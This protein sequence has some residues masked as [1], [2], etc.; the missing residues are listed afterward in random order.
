M[1]KAAE[2]AGR[3]L[4]RDF[5]EVENL[6]VSKKG[7]GDFVSAADL[8]AE[9]TIRYE[10]EKA[11][12]TFGFLMEESGETKGKD[13][14]RRFIVDPLDGTTNFLHGI[15]HWSISIA[16]EEKG[17]ITAGL[18]LNPITDELYWAERGVGAFVNNR[19]LECTKTNRLDDA[20]ILSGGIRNINMNEIEMLLQN[21]VH[22][23]RQ[24]GSAALDICFVAA[25]KVDGFWKRK[26]AAWDV[27]A[28]QLI[29]SEAR[30][31]FTDIDLGKDGDIYASDFVASNGHLHNDFR[32]TLLKAHTPAKN[33]EAEAS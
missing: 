6:Q 27:A 24:F 31:R 17:K 5:G 12:P 9:E 2:K 30:G 16:A 26:L 20:F 19:R 23:I 21:K 7:P 8:R 22:T 25:G 10:L 3:G 11:R 15:P 33:L 18:V 4:A 14:D 32:Q 28:A 29:L 1:I 13:P